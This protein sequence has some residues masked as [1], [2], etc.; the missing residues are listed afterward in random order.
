MR[1]PNRNIEIFSLSVLDLFASALGAFIMIAV[2]LFPS[3]RRDKQLRSEAEKLKLA[4]AD[5]DKLA[6]DASA[7]LKATL[8]KLSTETVKSKEA[9]TAL[10]DAKLKLDKA[11]E[12]LAKTFLVIS[13]EWTVTGADVDLH[14]TDPAGNLFNFSKN[15]RDRREYPQIPA[16]MS[17]DSTSGPGVEVWQ[18]PLATKG[19][20]KVEYVLYGVPPNSSVAIKGSIFE[21]HGYK[22]LPPRSLSTRGERVLVT[23]VSID[24]DGRVTL[25]P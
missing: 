20:Y 21:R 2:L 15:N 10:A 9:E 13:I 4:I 12:E 17:F 6:R 24:E 19:R 7:E 14:V 11:T 1:R 8:A 3:Y 18:H 25:E 23:T 22:E 16:Q 5:K